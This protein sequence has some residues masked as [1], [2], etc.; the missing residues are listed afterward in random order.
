MSKVDHFFLLEIKNQQT[1]GSKEIAKQIKVDTFF[2][3]GEIR[4]FCLKNRWGVHSQ[5]FQSEP[6][7]GGGCEGVK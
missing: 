2:L 3:L 1:S 5:N 4:F 6:Q 7:N